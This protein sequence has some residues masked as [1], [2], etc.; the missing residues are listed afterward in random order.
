MFQTS[1]LQFIKKQSFMQELL[2]LGP[3]MS[4]LGIF[5]IAILKNYCYVWNQHLQFSKMQIFVQK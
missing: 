1:I 2:N 5:E 3:K 4:Y